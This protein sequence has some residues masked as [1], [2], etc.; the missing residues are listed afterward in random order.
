MTL[1]LE[2][3]VTYDRVRAFKTV[4]LA[5]VGDLVDAIACALNL[6]PTSRNRVHRPVPHNVQGSRPVG[7]GEH[8]ELLLPQAARKDVAESVVVLDDQDAVVGHRASITRSIPE[9]RNC[10]WLSATMPSTTSLL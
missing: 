2:R 7:G 8:V 1:S 5:D 9:S 3:E 6:A 4:A 10:L